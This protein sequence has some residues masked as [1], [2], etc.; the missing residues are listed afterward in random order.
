VLPCR[1]LLVEDHEPTRHILT[2]LLTRAGHEVQ[3]AGSVTEAVEVAHGYPFDLLVSDVGLPDGSGMDLMRKL[4]NGHR[5]SGIALSGYG[6]DEDL[7]A[8]AS[9]GFQAHLVKPVE[10]HRL[11]AALRMVQRNR[12]GQSEHAA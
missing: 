11:E 6:M 1:I 2:R 12:A 9:A 3:T 8:T 5:F 10:W 4:S 7:K